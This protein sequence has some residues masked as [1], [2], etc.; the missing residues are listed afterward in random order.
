LAPSAFTVGFPATGSPSYNTA[1]WT[2]GCNTAPWNTTSAICGTVADSG[3][4]SSG[5]QQVQVSIQQGAGNYW[6]GSTFGSGSEVKLSATG[7]F[8]SANSTTVNWTLPFPASNLPADGSYTVRVYT[9][10]NVGNSATPPISRT[11]TYDSVAPGAPTTVALANGQGVGSAYINNSTKASVS[12]TVTGVQEVS[13]SDTVTV[14]VSDGTTS[15]TGNAA[16]STSTVTVTGIDATSL[17]N[18]TNNIT[19]SAKEADAAGN[20]S[21]STSAGT[22]Y[23]K[24]VTAPS[25]TDVTLV[26]VGAANGTAESGEKVTITYSEAI[27][28][29]TFCSTWTT[30]TPSAL[31]DVTVTIANSA[32]SDPLTVSTPTC[33][34]RLATVVPGDYVSGTTTFTSSTIA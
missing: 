2:A 33:T 31:T 14:T 25:V 15:V 5:V 26:S 9:N 18:G 21:G 11:F 28:A 17:A 4:T 30:E 7:A 12:V 20:N 23:S 29:S 3:A 13:A 1:G 10:D 22:T 16:A 27:R 24:D 32:G 19:I 34:F 8:P 6:D